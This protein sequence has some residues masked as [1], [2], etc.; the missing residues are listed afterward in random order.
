MVKSFRSATIQ[1]SFEA[2]MVT[3]RRNYR[4]YRGVNANSRG[5]YDALD[6]DTIDSNAEHSPTFFSSPV[7]YL[8]G[9]KRY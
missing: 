9:L 2:I 5:S 1:L 4:K 6:F 8:N 3:L 7:G